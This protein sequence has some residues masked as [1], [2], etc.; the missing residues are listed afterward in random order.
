MAKSKILLIDIETAPNLAWVWGK[1]EQNVIEFESDWYILSVAYKWLGDKKAHC[2]ALPQFS[3]YTKKPQDDSMLLKKV[4]ELL[5]EADVVI[6]HNGDSFD[7]K[8]INARLLID[9]IKPP[10]P[11]KT[12]DTKKVAKKYF[13][14][15]SNSLDDLGRQLGVGRKTDSGGWETWKGCISGDTS[16]WARMVKYNKE[17]VYLLEDVYL[18]LRPWMTNHPNMKVV[19]WDSK[20]CRNCG[21]DGKFI[22][23]GFNI[24]KN[25]RTQRV[26]CTRCGAFDNTGKTEKIV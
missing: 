14:F 20:A 18:T 9:K 15:D 22:K 8:K 24:N 10:S 21:E 13:K 1:Y 4:V 12:I 11:Y 25:G 23:R 26:Q 17:D 7:I 19:L 5:D 3:S 16:S 6:A 2:F